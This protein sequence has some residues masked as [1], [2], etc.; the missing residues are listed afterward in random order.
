MS[1]P[2][3]SMLVFLLAGQSNM[4]GRGGLPL[5]G[6]RVI[7]SPEALTAEA[8]GRRRGEL[9]D[10]LAS[11]VRAARD[12]HGTSG[13]TGGDGGVAGVDELCKRVYRLTCGCTT[14]P[15]AWRWEPAQDPLHWDVDTRKSCGVGPGMAFAV[16]LLGRLAAVH[17]RTDITIG[18]VPAAVGG[19]PLSD[20]L[21]DRGG[22]P[23]WGSSPTSLPGLGE[24]G[25][26]SL[27]KLAVA[28]AR[29][30]VEVAT[31]DTGATRAVLSGWLFYQGESDCG[32]TQLADTWCERFCS[33]LATPLRKALCE[34]AS[35]R[36]GQLPLV[37]A[38][39]HT[40]P[41]LP[42]CCCLASVRKQQLH[43][44]PN[45]LPRCSVVD[46][47]HLL[48]RPDGLHLTTTAQDLLGAAMAEAMMP[49][50]LEDEPLV[51]ND[52]L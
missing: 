15:R 14:D 28:R 18:L 35:K 6:P 2:S 41:T 5:Q 3:S 27:F 38:A 20:W 30:G 7:G 1:R 11:A 22:L 21:E 51:I 19:V 10:V 12:V 34:L 26:S 31:R 23:E 43:H 36:T 29:A 32:S 39:V 42:S 24:D 47:A 50:L 52:N 9:Q 46:T 48:L 4:A 49:W 45:T 8:I 40:D 17:G 37:V 16:A 44:V 13:G 25:A 33:G